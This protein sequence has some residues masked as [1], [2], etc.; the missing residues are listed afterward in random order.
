MLHLLNRT[1]TLYKSTVS[2]DMG[3]QKETRVS[4]WDFPCRY[5]Q[6][7]WSEDTQRIRKELNAHDEMLDL[8][9]MTDCPIDKDDKVEI[10]EA[11]Y[12]VLFMYPQPWYWGIHHLYWKIHRIR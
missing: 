5:E 11:S 6:T 10:W 7:S 2:N 12:K 3:T 4:S 8:Y 1:L 9:V